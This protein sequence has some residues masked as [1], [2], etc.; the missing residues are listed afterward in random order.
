MSMA[1]R[2]VTMKPEELAGFLRMMADEVARGASFEGQLR[3][4]VP[5]LGEW[6]EEEAPPVAPD[7]DLIY[8]QA[9]VRNNNDLGQGGM[10]LAGLV[11]DTSA[12]E[13]HVA[14]VAANIAVT[15]Q[16]RQDIAARM[17]ADMA[18]DNPL[19]SEEAL[20]ELVNHGMFHVEHLLAEL[21][22]AHAG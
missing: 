21:E 11:D 17:K 2:P 4:A 8:V 10:W 22:A 15:E 5:G 18:K 16:R 7:Q 6:T 12:A 9:A 3:Y 13:A 1:L 20:D 14:R 19:L